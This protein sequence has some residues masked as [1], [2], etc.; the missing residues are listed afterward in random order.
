MAKDY[1]GKLGVA[2]NASE[3]EIKSAYKKLAK[4]YHPDVSSETGAEEKFKEVQE[5]Y[6]VLGDATKRSNYDNLGEAGERFSGFG[7]FGSGDFSNVEFDFGDIF[8]DFSF[9]AWKNF[10]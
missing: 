10:P 3:A 9:I 4:K 7:G 1:Y 2:K 6:S 5:A 8:S